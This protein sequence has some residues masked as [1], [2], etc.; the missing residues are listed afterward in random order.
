MDDDDW[1]CDGDIGSIGKND[2][3]MV[4]ELSGFFSDSWIC[5]SCGN[6]FVQ[7][8]GGKGY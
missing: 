3:R 7:M 1:E 6:F 2:G 5:G 4:L 8:G